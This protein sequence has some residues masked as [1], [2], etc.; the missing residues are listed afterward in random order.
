MLKGWLSLEV[1]RQLLLIPVS[2]T[3]QSSLWVSII[4]R[5]FDYNAGGLY[6]KPVSVGIIS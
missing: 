2:V 3:K 5:L 1:M 6:V 4:Q